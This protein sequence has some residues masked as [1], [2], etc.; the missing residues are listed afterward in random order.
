[1][2]QGSCD[3]GGQQAFQALVKLLNGG[4]FPHAVLLL[5]N[6]AKLADE[7]VKS[8]AN[9]LLCCDNCQSHIDFFTVSPGGA[10]S[11]IVAD[12]MRTLIKN[13]QSSPK[14]G[15]RKVAYVQHAETM[16]KYAANSFLM[17]LEEPPSDTVI[18]LSAP[19]RYDLLPTILSRCL[20][21]K[22]HSEFNVNSPILEKIGNMYE[23]WLNSLIVK[24][25]FNLA[26]IEMYKILSNIE[27]NFD[28]L[29]EETA[30]PRPELLKT[31]VAKLEQKTAKIFM[32]NPQITPRLHE[33][34][35][36]FEK[37]KYFLSINCNIIA[38]L[39]RC[40]ILAVRFFEKN[41]NKGSE[42]DNERERKS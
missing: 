20:T 40:F 31:L 39:E 34:T 29:E 8:L 32:E 37:N 3:V 5:S 25:S 19:S 13:I 4:R 33:I 1:M 28:G 7:T 27:E 30:M 14:I 9:K 18:F 12:D 2:G 11:Q 15:R 16:N 24:T 6:E 42:Y 35:E 41:L 21:F 17:T 26:T 22:L 36:I 23:S 10:S 38:F